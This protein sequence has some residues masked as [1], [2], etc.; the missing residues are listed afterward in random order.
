M[1]LFRRSSNPVFRGI[2]SNSY[3]GGVYTEDYAD[4][5]SY[6]GVSRKLILLL[7][8]MTFSAMFS[9]TSLTGVSQISLIFAMVL[10]FVGVIGA[11]RSY[12]L[13][14]MF[15]ILYALAEGYIIGF[16][17]GVYNLYIPGIVPTA[18]FATF[19]VFFVM[20]ILYA[21]GV[22][23]VGNTFRRVM[24]IALFGYVFF[25]LFILISSWFNPTLMDF[26]FG[27]SSS[28]AY[29]LSIAL[30]VFASFFLLIDFDNVTRIVKS[31]ADKQYEWQ[32]ALGVM[33]GLIWL[34]IQILRLLMIIASRSSRR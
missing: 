24:M 9:F 4:S 14:P 26:F 19:S 30:V 27:P 5:A 34:Y 20:V 18:L 31:G 8:V 25:I 21:T 1:S 13:A 17:S 28:I 11:M 10:A 32:A 12:N 7:A 3:D 23:R 22:I 33:V 16:I 29:G 15:S 2:E 6:G